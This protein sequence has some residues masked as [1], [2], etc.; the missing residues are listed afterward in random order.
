MTL[1]EPARSGG[2]LHQ[3]GMA[4]KVLKDKVCPPSL[5]TSV[6]TVRTRNWSRP[7]GFYHSWRCY[8]TAKF[9]AYIC[10]CICFSPAL[11]PSSS[12]TDVGPKFLVSYR[13]H[14]YGAKFLCWRLS[15][16]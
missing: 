9:A 13:Y 7:M 1:G 14:S 10:I 2:F 8:H 15:F 3:G 11:L 12:F 6:L 16:R 5:G 4:G